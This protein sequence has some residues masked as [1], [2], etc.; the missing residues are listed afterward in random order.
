MALRREAARTS[1]GVTLEL[2]S[3]P[4]R[5][6]SWGRKERSRR[7]AACCWRHQG[8]RLLDSLRV[9]MRVVLV[10]YRP[11]CLGCDFLNKVI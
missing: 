10:S 5:G 9:R 4:G 11:K 6:E 1:V 8:R 7:K 2:R 3:M